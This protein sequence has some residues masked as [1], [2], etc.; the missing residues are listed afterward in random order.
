MWRAQCPGTGEEVMNRFKILKR[1]NVE[2]DLVDHM[3]VKLKLF[4]TKLSLSSC[5][6]V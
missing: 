1:P 5:M 2:V 4:E 3:G 6:G